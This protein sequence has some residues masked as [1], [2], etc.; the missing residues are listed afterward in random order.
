[1]I[2]EKSAKTGRPSATSSGTR[3]DE[4]VA[5]DEDEDDDDEWMDGGGGAKSWW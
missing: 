5:S 2:L 3:G 4:R 1:M